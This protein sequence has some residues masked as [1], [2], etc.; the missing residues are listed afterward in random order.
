MAAVPKNVLSTALYLLLTTAGL[1]GKPADNL[2]SGVLPRLSSFNVPIPEST[3]PSGFSMKIYDVPYSAT[4]LEKVAAKDQYDAAVSQGIA[5][6][7]VTIS[8]DS[9]DFM[10]VSLNTKPQT[11]T[12]NFD[13]EDL[14]TSPVQLARNDEEL[15]SLQRSQAYVTVRQ[16]V[17]QSRNETDASA[18]LQQALDLSLQHDLVTPV[19][20]ML[21]ITNTT[22][23]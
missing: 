12:L 18:L 22:I 11:V 15:T 16:L 6:G 1:L 9:Y 7:Y 2:K 10:V 14:V 5:A 4:I 21:V 19:T 20:A 17:D 23:Y 3:Y 13:Y 8:E